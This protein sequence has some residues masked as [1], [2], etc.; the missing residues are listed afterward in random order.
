VVAVAVAV[1]VAAAGWALEDQVMRVLEVRNL[2]MP[3]HIIRPELI[4]PAG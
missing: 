2:L 3:N 1:A 4:L